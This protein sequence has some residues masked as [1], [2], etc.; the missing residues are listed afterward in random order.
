LSLGGGGVAAEVLAVCD[1][2]RAGCREPC[3]GRSWHVSVRKA[4]RAVFC[5]MVNGCRGRCTLNGGPRVGE[6]V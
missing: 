2:H 4:R 1:M 6:T 5:D 3:D